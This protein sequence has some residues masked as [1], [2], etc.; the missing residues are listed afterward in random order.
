LTRFIS[1][2]VVV[3]Y[4]AGAALAIAVTQLFPFF[5]IREMGGYHPVYRQ[6]WYLIGHIYTLHIPTTLLAI[7]CLTVLIGFLSHLSE[8]SWSSN[9]VFF[10]RWDCSA[11]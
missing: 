8:D 3:G 11:F 6:G 7:C 1:R 9:C 5:G 10:I 4:V 2:S